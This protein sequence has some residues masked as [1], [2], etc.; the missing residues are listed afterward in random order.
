MNLQYFYAK[1]QAK[2]IW[3]KIAAFFIILFKI[4]INKTESQNKNKRN[5]NNPN[6]ISNTI[7]KES[8]DLHITNSITN[9]N[10]LNSNQYGRI[11]KL[12]V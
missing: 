6:I 10:Y 5:R 9:N 11:L 8:A 2:I 1:I 7:S 4:K 12:Y 3:K